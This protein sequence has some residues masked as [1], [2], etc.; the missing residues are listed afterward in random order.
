MIRTGTNRA[1]HERVPTGRSGLDV[2]KGV[3]RGATGDGAARPCPLVDVDRVRRGD[4]TEGNEDEERGL[5]Y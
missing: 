1:V 4:P 5:D 2:G 3:L